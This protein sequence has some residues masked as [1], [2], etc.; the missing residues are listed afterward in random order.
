MGDGAGCLIQ[1]PDSLL[2]DWTKTNGYQLPEIG[3]Y[4]VAMCFLPQGEPEKQAAM[5][6]LERF[7]KAEGQTL[8]A[9]RPVPTDLS[10][11][12][13][14]VLETMPGIYQAIILRDPSISDQNTFER[15]LLTIRK[16]TLNSARSEQ[17]LLSDLYIPSFSSRTIVYKGLLL[18]RQVGTFYRDLS[19]PPKVFNQHFPFMAFSSPI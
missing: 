14:R 17:G 13:K 7:V 2:R 5:E 1:I 18:A 10:G 6:H 9:W 19:N 15:K 3:H 8:L 4:A 16:Q 11:I 12:G